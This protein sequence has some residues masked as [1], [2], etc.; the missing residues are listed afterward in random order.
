[1]PVSGITGANIKEVV[2][3][4]V[5][6]WYE[7]DSLIQ[8]LDKLKLDSKN[9]ESSPVR[10]PITAK[11]KDMGTTII[12]GKLESGTISKGQSLLIMPNKVGLLMR[13]GEGRGRR[14]FRILQLFTKQ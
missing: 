1:M 14:I 7:G 5:C 8:T 3:K 9:L 6:S 4:D 11:Y 10:M 13:E 2:S 12:M